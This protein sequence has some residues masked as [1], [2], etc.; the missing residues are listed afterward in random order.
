MSEC[1]SRSIIIKGESKQKINNK[2]IAL[3]TKN[4]KNKHT[5]FTITFTMVLGLEIVGIASIALIF[6]L[7]TFAGDGIV[8]PMVEGCATTWRGIPFIRWL[9]TSECYKKTGTR[10]ECQEN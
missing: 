4:G 9:N 5:L 2:H 3:T 10:N 6:K 1:G 7:A 8:V